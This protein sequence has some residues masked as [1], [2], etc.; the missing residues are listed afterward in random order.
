MTN[1]EII[2]DA[3]EAAIETTANGFYTTFSVVEDEG[4]YYGD[5]EAALRGVCFG[6]DHTE[7]AESWPSDVEGVSDAKMDLW[8]E[9]WREELFELG[10]KELGVEL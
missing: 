4:P 5:V 10:C 1:Q 6:D 8:L 3:R 7:A 9:T 2:Q